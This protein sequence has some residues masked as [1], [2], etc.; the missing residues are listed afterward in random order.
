MPGI[1]SPLG[2]GGQQRRN[3]NWRLSVRRLWLSR[4]SRS[5]AKVGRNVSVPYSRKPS[6]DSSIWKFLYCRT[7]RVSFKSSWTEKQTAF[8]LHRKQ[9]VSR[10]SSESPAKE[11]LVIWLIDQSKAQVYLSADHCNDDVLEVSAAPA[12]DVGPLFIAL[13]T[14]LVNH[15]LSAWVWKIQ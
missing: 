5:S 13:L 6:G 7:D 3:W 11:T 12:Q 1:S 9:I 15:I 10:D 8:K 4:C 14:E 2:C